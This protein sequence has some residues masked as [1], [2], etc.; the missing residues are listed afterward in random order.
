M[1]KRLHSS[2]GQSVDSLHAKTDGRT[3]TVNIHG[4]TEY[5][6]T[7]YLLEKQGVKSKAK[8]ESRFGKGRSFCRTK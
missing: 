4:V 1:K 6:C 5:V 7:Y 3:D 8:K 2:N